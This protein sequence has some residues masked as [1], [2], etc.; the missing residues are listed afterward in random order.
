MNTQA[1]TQANTQENPRSDAQITALANAQASLR[2]TPQSFLVGLIGSGIS[3][4]LTPAM[5]EEEGSN[6]GLHYVYRRIDLDA[7]KLD[8]AALPELLTAAERMGY[9]GLNIT[10]PCKQAVI[11]LL[12]ELSDDA[13]ALGAVNT[14]LFKDGKRIGH[15]T[16]WSGFARAFQRGLPDV[17]LERVVQLGA[18]GAGAAVAHAAL[19][20]GAQSL[21]LFDVDAARAQ[22]LA[23]ELQARFPQAKVSAGTSLEE[24]LAA[25]QGLIH[26][27]PTGMA[28][29]PGLPLPAELL[30]RDLWVADIVYFPIRTA[31]LQAAE[32]L[33]CR[34]LSGGGMAV[35]QAV[36][37]MRIF[38]GLEPDAER[39]Y[40][41][42]QSLLQ[43]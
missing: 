15:N 4:S 7:Q 36:D 43:R 42:F 34:T 31:L 18:G 6:L 1:N 3:G 20:M 2:A 32:A 16:D 30:H 28:K 17:S 10:Y 11:P 5:H 13:R 41:H 14:V 19:N 22:S 21:T 25:A 23:D 37:A 8:T 33:G 38:T 27:T 24:S 29:M 40:T 39:V 35:Y 12:D 9:N 26:A